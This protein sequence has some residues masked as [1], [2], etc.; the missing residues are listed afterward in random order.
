MTLKHRIQPIETYDALGVDVGCVLIVKPGSTC[1][2]PL[3][4]QDSTKGHV[5]VV[6]EG[7]LA[8]L[9]TNDWELQVA[10]GDLV[11]VLDPSRVALNGVRRDADQLDAALGELWLQLGEG[12][13]LGCAYWRV[14]FWM[15]EENDPVVANE[16][17]ELDSSLGGVC[18]KIGRDAAQTE[19]LRARIRRTHS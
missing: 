17:M 12:A 7:N 14:V 8:V 9:V 1:Q 2:L 16:I 5:H 3:P 4:P 18:L 10:P 15:R 19:G 6:E 13:E 11:D